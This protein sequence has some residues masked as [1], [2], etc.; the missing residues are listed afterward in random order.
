MRLTR[1]SSQ[2]PCSRRR[3]QTSAMAPR[4]W[5]RRSLVPSR[6]EDSK[7]SA[8]LVPIRGWV[9]AEES[10]PKSPE[11]PTVRPERQGR[12]TKRPEQTQRMQARR[13][14][15]LVRANATVDEPSSYT[16]EMTLTCGGFRITSE[17]STLATKDGRGRRRVLDGRKAERDRSR[18]SLSGNHASTSRPLSLTTASRRHSTR[19]ARVRRASALSMS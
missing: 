2:K 1:S 13:S 4:A 11:S 10:D 3:S 15:S 18:F 9:P 6:A 12:Q 8:H 14:K 7:T 17:P 19:P 16:D 5:Q